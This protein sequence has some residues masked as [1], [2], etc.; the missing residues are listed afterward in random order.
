[1]VLENMVVMFV[2][3][4]CSLRDEN[5]SENVI[6]IVKIYAIVFFSCNKLHFDIE[7]R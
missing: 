7:Y 4:N 2:H 3:L 1:M 6:Y 5:M